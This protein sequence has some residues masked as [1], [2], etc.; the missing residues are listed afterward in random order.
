MGRRKRHK[1]VVGKADLQGGINK[2]QLQLQLQLQQC[3]KYSATEN[4]HPE[5]KITVT[6]QL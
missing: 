5:Y 4:N 6:R 1:G 3:H 2:I